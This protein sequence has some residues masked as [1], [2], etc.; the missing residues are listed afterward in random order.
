[1]CGSLHNRL[2]D[3]FVGTQLKVFLSL[4]QV[5]VTSLI[6]QRLT[7][8][9]FTTL[10][11]NMHVG[12]PALS[13]FVRL[14]EKDSFQKRRTIRACERAWER[15]LASKLLLCVYRLSGIEYNAVICFA[16]GDLDGP[17]QI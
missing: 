10:K 13:T 7:D 5:N 17:L 9:L 16:I 8:V 3:W 15:F 4:I 1:M 11:Q 14:L 2:P 12:F 6:Q